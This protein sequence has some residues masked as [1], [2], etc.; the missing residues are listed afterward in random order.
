MIVATAP[1]FVAPH[2]SARTCSDSPDCLSVSVPESVVLPPK[3]TA[4]GRTPR[5]DVGLMRTVTVP[6]KFLPLLTG[7]EKLNLP[8]PVNVQLA[9]PFGCRSSV[10][11]VQWNPVV[12]LKLTVC[13][14]V[15]LLLKTTASPTKIETDVGL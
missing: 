14:T 13:A 15:S 12:C 11:S 2:W 1:A 8:A 10:V 7:S 4:L 3:I 6:R 5:L 9:V